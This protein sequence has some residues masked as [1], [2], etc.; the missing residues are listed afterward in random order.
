MLNT[1]VYYVNKAMVPA[2][3]RYPYIEKLT[4][5]LVMLIRKLKPYF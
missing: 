4:L 5:A 1:K 2:E 3:K